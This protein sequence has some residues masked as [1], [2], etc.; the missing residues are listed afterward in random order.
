MPCAIR[1]GDFRDNAGTPRLDP[2]EERNTGKP[3]RAQL[4]PLLPPRPKIAAGPSRRVYDVIVV[5]GQLAGALSAALL[6]KR[7]YRVLLVEHDGMGHGYEHGEF[8]LPYA[9]FVA[10][11]LRTMPQVEEAFSELGLTTTIQRSLKSNVPDLQLILPKDRI[12][13]PHDESRRASELARAFGEARAEQINALFKLAAT[14]HEQTDAFFKE[15]PDLPPNSFVESWALKKQIRRHPNLDARLPLAGDDPVARLLLGLA[16]FVTYLAAPRGPLPQT[17]TLSQVLKSSTRYP[18][19][20]EGLRELLCKRLL[21]LGGDLLWRESAESSIVESLTFEGGKLVGVQILRSEN[22]YR[23]SYLIVSTDSAA[24]RR[25]IPDKKSQRKLIALLD[26]S[27]VKQFLFSVNWV[28]SADAIPKGMGDLLLFDTG[29]LDLEPLLVQLHAP[30]RV[31]SKTEDESTRVVTAGVFV[32]ASA[33]DLGEGYLKLLADRIGSHLERLMP[34]AK[35]HLLLSSAPYLDA[36]GVRGA[37]LLPHPLYEIDAE[38]FLGITGLTQQ[39]PLKNL[40]LASRE[41]LPGL[42]LEGEFLA[43]IR[44]ARLIQETMNKKDPLKRAG[45]WGAGR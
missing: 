28:V 36:G 23:A 11:Q 26:L 45:L 41:T 10:Q 42:G 24:V 3:Q 1:A 38:D 44:V 30:R 9:P 6:A 37:R 14:Q 35:D 43:G 33:R 40:F 2:E 20:R 12:D 32:P 39:T 34:F 17:R 21:D 22:V 29:D 7:G 4:M 19:S 25:L 8:V 31:G 27:V 13:F 16:P 18:G 15:R 5:G